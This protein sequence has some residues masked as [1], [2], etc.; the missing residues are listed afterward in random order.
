MIRKRKLFAFVGLTSLFCG[1]FA[2]AQ[3]YENVP[4]RRYNRWRGAV[5]IPADRNG[6]PNWDLNKQFEKDVFTFVRIQYDSYGRWGWNTDFPDADLNL[7]YR[8]Q[9]LTS[10]K[11]HPEGK[12][13]RLTDP[14]LYDYPFIYIIEPGAMRL[15]DDEVLALRRYLNRGGFLLVD[16]FWG[17]REWNNLED[18]M[19]RVLPDRT[20]RELPLEHEIFHMV[21][22]LK[23]KPIIPS[24][25]TYYN[26][27]RTERA[28][29]QV[30]HYRAYEDDD[31]RIMVMVCHNTDL[32]DGW[33][34][35]G[36]DRGY[37]EA[38][39]EPF[40]YPLGINIVTY[41]MTH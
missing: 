15:R 16:D 2:L 20:W 17:E 41:A 7:S 40:A 34:R 38:Y 27:F 37:F 12:V 5:R 36:V 10:M 4:I 13:I 26:G 33:E 9:Q 21:Y 39:S 25:H 6:V 32:G 18:E 35:E 28:D 24:I 19:R 30:G 1:L 31:G 22:D 23:E 11:V 3:D 29:A 14:S 8:L